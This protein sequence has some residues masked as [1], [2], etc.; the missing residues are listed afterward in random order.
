[1]KKKNKMRKFRITAITALVM[2]FFASVIHAQSR[3][4][5]VNV[6]QID[7]KKGGK[8]KIGIYD[9]NEFPVVGKELFGIALE[10]KEP[11]VTH[12][13]NNIPVGKYAVAVFQDEN[14][15][16]ILN[17]NSFGAPK[18]RYGFSKNKYA[19]FGSPDFEDVSFEVKENNP[20]SFTINLE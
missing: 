14:N 5:T 6:T 1:M 16:G 13:F 17:K 4:I 7:V 10:V 11:S 2:L 19:M 8:V 20:I 18:E 12:V 15:D 9:S 3:M